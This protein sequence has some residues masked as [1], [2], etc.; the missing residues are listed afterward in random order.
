MESLTKEKSR[1]GVWIIVIGNESVGF[2][3]SRT[4]P[5]LPFPRFQ[6]LYLDEFIIF[7]QYILLPFWDELYSSNPFIYHTSRRVGTVLSVGIR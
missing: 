7:P 3:G 5:T 2:A 4:V 6:Q 1:D